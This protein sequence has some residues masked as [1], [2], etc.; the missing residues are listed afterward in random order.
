MKGFMRG[1]WNDR[2]MR[3]KCKKFSRKFWIS[4]IFWIK[5]TKYIFSKLIDI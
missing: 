5:P 2:N 1:D 4:I 3:K